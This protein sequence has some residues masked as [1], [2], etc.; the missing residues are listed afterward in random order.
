[1]LTPEKER[2][3][4]LG[5]AV[6]GFDL[7]LFVHGDV[8]S[9]CCLRCGKPAMNLRRVGCAIRTREV[10]L[11]KCEAQVAVAAEAARG[12]RLH[13]DAMEKRSFWNQ[14]VRFIR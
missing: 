7:A 1:M 4:E 3:D 2:L 6:A 14:Q 12:F 8:L 9:G 11:A 13:D 5:R 10:E